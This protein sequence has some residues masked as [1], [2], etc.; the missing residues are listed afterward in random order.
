M[1]PYMIG[2]IVEF[3]YNNGSTTIN[4]QGKIVTADNMTSLHE[5]DIMDEKS[6][7]LYKHIPENCVY[8]V[9][10]KIK[11]CENEKTQFYCLTLDDYATPSFCSFEKYY[12]GSI[13]MIESLVNIIEADKR[14]V[15]NHSQFIQA[16][17][18]YCNGNTGVTHNVAYKEMSLLEP[19]SVYTSIKIKTGFNKLE[20][21]NTWDCNYYMRWEQAESEH[22]WI[23]HKDR[24]FRCIKASFTDLQ[25]SGFDKEDTYKELIFTMGFPGIVDISS[26]S[27]FNRLFVS[28]KI[29][30]NKEEMLCDA[31]KFEN[32]PDPIYTEIFNDIFGDG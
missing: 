31:E 8:G 18:E 5:Y 17:K 13:P 20:H 9:V 16:F 26:N 32:A 7:I 27:V 1:K 29:F 6:K 14:W 12:F 25:Y 3:G 21:L 11:Y 22:I 15:D 28:E 23:K 30:E 24:Y 19:V 10:D 2:Q 4:H